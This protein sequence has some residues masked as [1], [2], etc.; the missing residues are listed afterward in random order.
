M[1][2]DDCRKILFRACR[3]GARE[4]PSS[5]MIASADHRISYDSPAKTPA[6]NFEMLAARMPQ[7]LTAIR[8]WV[9][10]ADGD[11]LGLLLG[12]LNA[13]MT[14]SRTQVE[15]QRRSASDRLIGLCGFFSPLHE[16]R[17]GS[18]SV[19]NAT[20]PVRFR[21]VVSLGCTTVAI[22]PLHQSWP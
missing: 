16:H 7:A 19:I 4:Y 22:P 2:V 14:A 15:N 21:C 12:A 3:I 20:E 8:R 9:A 1:A 18:S 11:E 5:R 17:Y 10:E 13:R 6:L